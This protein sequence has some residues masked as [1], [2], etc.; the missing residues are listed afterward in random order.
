MSIRSSGRRTGAGAAA[1]AIG[2]SVLLVPTAAGTARA[3]P[4]PPRPA[5]ALDASLLHRAG[6]HVRARQGAP[7]LPDDVSALS[8][9]VADAG[10]G[11]VLAAHDAH[12]RLPPASTLKTLFALTA[13]PRLP[14]SGR[15]TVTE[16]ELDEVPEGSSTVGLSADHTYRVADLW[17]GVFLSSGNDAVHVLAEMNGGWDVTSAQMQAKARALG[18]RDTTVV[19]PDGFDADGQASSA[20]DLAVFGRAGLADPAFAEYAATADARFPGGTNADGSPTWT[21]GI[22]NTNRLVT[23]QDGM[24]RY[25]GIIGVKNGYT[26]QAGF[27]LIAAARRDGR[28]L[29]ATVM[30][31]QWGGANAVYEE[32]RSLLDWG[33]AAAGRVDPVGSLDPPPPPA[34]PPA[35]PRTVAARAVVRSGVDVGTPMVYGLSAAFLAAVA[36][37]TG[38][39][40]LRRRRSP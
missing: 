6:T 20:Y 31:P 30:N 40:V 25:P 13:L 15:H 11:A 37:L 12:R 39:A 24:G 2:A 35:T 28:T 8:W 38:A 7:A 4:L 19:S 10:T 17:R 34:A 26:S 33:F 1:L 36:A 9:L 16:A 3:E 29:L 5:P 14:G 21:Y 32:A 22:E 18:A 23:G 27:T